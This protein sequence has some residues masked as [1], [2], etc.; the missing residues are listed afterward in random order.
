[1]ST[2]QPATTG[3]DEKTLAERAYRLLRGDIVAG[4][5]EPGVKLKIDA[6]RQQYGLGAGPLR[7]ALARLSGDHLVRIEGQRGFAVAP[8]SAEDARDIGAMRKLL[9]AQALRLSIANGNEAW[10]DSVVTAFH[11][12][13]RVEKR[14]SEGTESHA[15]WELRNGQF[16]EAL[17]AACGSEWLKR[18]RLL[19]FQQHERYRRLSRGRTMQTRDIHAEH[20]EFFDAVLARDADRA[21]AASDE[22]IERTTQAVIEALRTRV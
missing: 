4:S 20:K 9:E 21:V 15:T 11:R 8:M 5:L 3:S 7:E 1:M 19:I 16:H 12:L 14:L 10:E 6:L 2:I 17:V 18:V 13:E 22:H